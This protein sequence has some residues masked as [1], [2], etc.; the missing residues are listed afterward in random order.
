MLVGWS[1]KG[2]VIYWEICLGSVFAEEMEEWEPLQACSL[3]SS[4]PQVCWGDLLFSVAWSHC[5]DGVAGL[6]VGGQAERQRWLSGGVKGAQICMSS[7]GLGTE[8]TSV[9][10]TNIPELMALIVGRRL[11]A[12]MAQWWEEDLPGNMGGKWRF[13]GVACP[14]AEGHQCL[15]APT[16]TKIDG[17]QSGKKSAAFLHL[18]SNVGLSCE[19]VGRYW[20]N[21]GTP[22][23]VLYVRPRSLSIVLGRDRSP[24]HWARP[25]GLGWALRVTLI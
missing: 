22:S 13:S 15:G 16:S 7:S 6:G 25:V 1:L 5:G 8:E 3:G 4:L 10:K 12:R 21:H 9:H 2:R 18:S 14:T 20:F 23:H 24:V 19:W 17:Y 11:R